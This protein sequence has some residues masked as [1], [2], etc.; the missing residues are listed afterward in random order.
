MHF[1]GCN[2]LVGYVAAFLT[3]VS[4]VPQLLRVIRL[5]TAR[6]LSLGMDPLT[7]SSLGECGNACSCGE[8]PDS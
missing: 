7:A 4:F 1:S 8:Y 6:D 2:S 3:T 5:K